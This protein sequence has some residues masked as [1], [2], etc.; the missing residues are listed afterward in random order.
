[1]FESGG[2]GRDTARATRAPHQRGVHFDFTGGENTIRAA[3]T[4]ATQRGEATGATG[5]PPMKI[6]QPTWDVEGDTAA[7][8]PGGT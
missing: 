6:T 5:T 1:M 7:S 3:D 4:T 2:S 8:A